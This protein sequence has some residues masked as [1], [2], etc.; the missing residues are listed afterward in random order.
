MNLVDEP[1]IPC[2]RQDG[3]TRPASLLDCFAC[4]GLV[5]L[6]V[7]PHE[8][9]ALMRLLLCISYAALGIPEDYD[10]WEAARQR[11]AAEVP[12]Y[13]KRWQNAF[14]LF[15]PQTPFLQVPGLRSA[16]KNEDLTPCSKLDFALATGNNST[17]F[18]HAGQAPRAFPP[19]WLA[20]NLLTFQMFSPGGLI[21]AV[22]WGGRTTET[23]SS[24]SPCAPASML[25]TLLRR[26]TLPD[27]IHANLLCEEDLPDYARLGEGWQGRPLWERFPRDLDDSAAIHNATRTFLGRMVPLSRAILLAPGGRSMVLGNGLTFPSFTNASN[28]FPPEV[29]ATVVLAGKKTERILLGAQPSKAIWRQLA[30]L[31]VSRRAGEVGGCAALAHCDPEQGADLVVAGLARSK[32]DILDAVESVFRVPGALF[33]DEGHQVYEAET[34]RAEALGW[35]LGAAVALFRQLADGGWQNRLRNAGAQKSELLARLK[36][37]AL[38]LYWTSVETGLPLLWEAVRA[39]GTPAFR[40]AQLAWSAHL[41]HSALQAYAQACGK[42]TE[43]QM[44]A[45][46]QGRRNLAGMARALLEHEE[47][48]EEA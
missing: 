8:R 18:D 7:R 3:T 24:D 1:W 43:R 41:R 30:A 44:R 20:L 19:D 38:R 37:W 32:A 15:H 48:K 46:V 42:D 28:P 45:Y 21:G 22:R 33:R 35:Q 26:A 29:S 12:A 47:R 4:D 5:A 9:V 17:L 31:T 6:A 27:S 2:L 13:L 34:E 11:L 40:A 36:A 25:H 10:A 39:C 16:S 14:D 23:H